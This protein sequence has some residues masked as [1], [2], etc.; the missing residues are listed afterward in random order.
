VK[1]F[2]LNPTHDKMK[3][4]DFYFS[5]RCTFKENC[6]YSHGE[7]VKYSDV[8]LFQAPDYKLLKKRCHVLVK[9]EKSLWKPGSVLE[10][11]PDL[12]T[13]QVKL[14]NSTKTVSLPFSEI[15]PPI[16]DRKH[17]SSSDLSTDDSSDSEEDLENNSSRN[18]LQIDDNFGEWEKYTTGFGSKMLE[19]YGYK[20]GLGLGKSNEF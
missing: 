4:C 1:V 13:C 8:K 11:I 6:K 16:N 5:D 12:E 20:S 14:H 7:I 15:L 3:A 18:V 9:T 10:C 17:E 19:K 2:Y